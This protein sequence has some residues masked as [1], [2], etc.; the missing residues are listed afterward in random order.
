MAIIQNWTKVLIKPTDNLGKGIKVIQKSGLRIA[1]V[2]DKN[3]TH[4][5]YH[6]KPNQVIPN[7]TKWN[8]THLFFMLQA[9]YVFSGSR[10]KPY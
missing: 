3:N 4:R 8:I 10:Y 6:K 1:L 2:V 9:I 5:Q 7:Q